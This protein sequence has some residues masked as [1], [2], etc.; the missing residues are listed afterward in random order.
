MFKKDFPVLPGGC[1]GRS[2]ESFAGRLKYNFF[3]N[4]PQLLP[5]LQPD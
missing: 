3:K 5:A 1:A 4:T 2:G